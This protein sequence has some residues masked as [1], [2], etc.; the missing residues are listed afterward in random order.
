M[1]IA[2]SIP[3]R[4]ESYDCG[5]FAECEANAVR[6]FPVPVKMP[7][8]I[9]GGL[10]GLGNAVIYNFTIYLIVLFGIYF[11]YTKLIKKGKKK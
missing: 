1:A 9:S 2:T 11:A 4:I 10:S 8:S 7:A 6:G 5:P 3:V